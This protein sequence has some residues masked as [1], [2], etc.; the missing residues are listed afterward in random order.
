MARRV[1]ARFLGAGPN[2]GW[3]KRGEPEVRIKM[4][5]AH[6]T[7]DLLVDRRSAEL[8][9]LGAATEDRSSGQGSKELQARRF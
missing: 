1:V 5:T 8:A 7:I 9:A 2:W 3:K 4:R 6:E